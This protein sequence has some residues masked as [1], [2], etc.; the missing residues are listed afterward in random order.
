[1]SIGFIPALAENASGW[2]TQSRCEC[3]RAAHSPS[4]P[5]RPTA[6]GKHRTSRSAVGVRGGGADRA[7][8]TTMRN[9]AQ[10]PWGHP[11]GHALIGERAPRR[12]T[13][14]RPARTWNGKRP[15]PHAPLSPTR[16]RSGK[17]RSGGNAA[18]RGVPPP[19]EAG[20]RHARTKAIRS[21]AGVNSETPLIEALRSPAIL[22][23]R[24]GGG[25]RKIR[26]SRRSTTHR[27]GQPPSRAQAPSPPN[28]SRT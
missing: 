24:E 26:P 27:T 6:N 14:E 23:L 8:R 20:S 15:P 4:P 18:H 28:S 19:L 10:A 25:G 9:G 16:R 17:R 11:A 3:C 21:I 12:S 5:P 7:N 13:A 22:E 2:R 1:M